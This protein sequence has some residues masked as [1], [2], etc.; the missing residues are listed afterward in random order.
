[1]WPSKRGGW[2]GDLREGD[3]ACGPS[4]SWRGR[5]RSPDLHKVQMRDGLWPPRSHVFSNRGHKSTGSILKRWDTEG[6]KDGGGGGEKKRKRERK[7]EKGR[8]KEKK[9]TVAVEMCASLMNLC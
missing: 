6:K 2:A 9:I 8:K 7:K 1:M 3:G 5:A 4:F